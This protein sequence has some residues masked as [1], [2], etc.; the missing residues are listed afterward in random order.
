MTTSSVE[1]TRLCIVNP[2]QFGGGAE[3]QINCLVD[4]LAPRKAYEIH[5]LAHHTDERARSDGAYRTVR[6]GK[7]DRMSP[8]GYLAD[9]P[10]LFRALKSINPHVIYQRVACAYTGISAFYVG[11]SAARMIWHVAHDSDVTQGGL[12]YGRNPLRRAIERRTVEYGIRHTSYIVA[13][14]EH[15]AKLLAHHYGRKAD[16]VIPNFH[17]QPVETIDKAGPL[18]VVW[19]AN[20]KRWKQPEVFVRL[21]RALSEIAGAR[22]VM[23]GAP[24]S[25]DREWGD[26]LMSSIVSTPNLEYVG[27][28]TQEEVNAILARAH[29]FVNTSLEEGFPNTYIQAWMR[30]VPVVSLNVNPDDVFNREAVGAFANGSEAELVKAVRALLTDDKLRERQAARAGEYAMSKHS[31]QNAGRLIELIDRARAESPPLHR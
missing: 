4:A 6:I 26:A 2:F 5:Y 11:K 9:A 30:R 10:A 15:Q 22:F 8:L 3:Y 24:V 27:L 28:K 31:V 23:V 14:K 21:A 1:K 12:G 20:F 25:G 17:P 18:T 19:I 7:S 29:V 16:A 13:Q